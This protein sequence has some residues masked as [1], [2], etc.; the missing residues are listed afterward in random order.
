MLALPADG[1][2][3]ASAKLFFAPNIENLPRNMRLHRR[4]S[5][6]DLFDLAILVASH[7]PVLS[8]AT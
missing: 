6:K 5:T 3:R 4:R 7:N 8:D 1:R 2:L